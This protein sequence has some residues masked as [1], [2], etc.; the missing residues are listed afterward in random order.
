MSVR[1][2][3]SSPASK[4]GAYHWL[5]LLACFPL[6]VLAAELPGSVTTALREAELEKLLGLL[7]PL[8]GPDQEFTF[9]ANNRTADNANFVGAELGRLLAA[10]CG[11]CCFG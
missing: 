2:R 11:R 7:R 6:L 1:R 4:R 10:A 8:R 3:V 5:A 9:E